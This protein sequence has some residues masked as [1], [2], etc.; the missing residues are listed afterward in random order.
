M[1][2]RQYSDMNEGDL[3]FDGYSSSCTGL[4]STDQV[5]YR[6]PLQFP[7]TEIGTGQ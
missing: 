3:G 4:R 6:E 7:Q 5:V 1:L 2:A